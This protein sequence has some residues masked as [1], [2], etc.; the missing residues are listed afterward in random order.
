[1]VVDCRSSGKIQV[2]DPSADSIV[3]TVTVGS[4]PRGMSANGSLVAVPNSFSNSVSIVDTSVNPATVTTVPV[5]S[6]PEWTAFL[7]GKIYVANF[8][9]N[10]VSILNG[11]APYSV[12]TTVA[13]GNN[14]QGIDPCAGNI[15]TSNRWTG[16]SS[17]I[18]P[19]SNSVTDT[20]P[21]AGVGAITHVMG[22]NG[23]YAFFLNFSPSTVSIVDCTAKTVSAT[24]PT[25]TNPG[26]IAFSSANA[27]VAGS[28]QL[29]AIALASSSSD[30]SSSAAPR[31]T[32]FEFP[33]VTADGTHCTSSSQTGV[34]GTW[35]TLP[36][37]TDCTPPPSKPNVKLLGW[38][39]SPD[40]PVTLAARQINN[41]WGT[42]ETFGPAGDL[43]GVFIPA[44][45][46]ALV[47]GGT[48]LYAIWSE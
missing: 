13:V 15:F 37:A 2:I 6:Q 4:G 34:R 30:G 35:M 40:F 45:R 10:T 41:N 39:T 47:T 5:G 23:N 33:L 14:P 25:A 48:T 3:Q 16:N 24:V 26:S 36:A 46:S 11:T 29:T 27:Y 12:I 42:Y 18:S 38:A 20:I 19:T 31:P 9:G 8:A 1:M 28:N 44:G 7:G 22:V 17:V 32:T 21:L 43:T